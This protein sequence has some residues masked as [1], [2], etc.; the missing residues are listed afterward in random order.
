MSKVNEVDMG[1]CYDWR[2]RT[3]GT[4]VTG[5]RTAVQ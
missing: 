3:F 2:L 4:L 5:C 1:R